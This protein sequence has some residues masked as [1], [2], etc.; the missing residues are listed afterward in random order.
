M[1]GVD[2]GGRGLLNDAFGLSQHLRQA[3]GK[4]NAEDAET[5]AL[6]NEVRLRKC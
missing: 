3:E 1:H 4:A 5:V 6:R 2:F